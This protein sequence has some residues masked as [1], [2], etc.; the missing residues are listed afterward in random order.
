[1]DCEL[2]NT[3]SELRVV[4]VDWREEYNN[5]R[6]HRCLGL[7]TAV[8]FNKKK[9]STITEIVSLKVGKTAQSNQIPI[10]SYYNT[11]IL[12]PNLT[13]T[14]QLRIRHIKYIN[15]CN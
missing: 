9:Y 1:M 6:P 15:L 5:I 4:V 2:L 10:Y 11:R 7:L 8:Q 3:L 13:F 12:I 14:C